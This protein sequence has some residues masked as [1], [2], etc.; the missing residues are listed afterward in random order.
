MFT[1]SRKY[2]NL[3]GGR[4]GH[5][6]EETA[7]KWTHT[8]Y[9]CCTEIQYTKLITN[10]C[11]KWMLIPPTSWTTTVNTRM[12]SM[13]GIKVVSILTNFLFK[14]LTHDSSCKWFIQVEDSFNRAKCWFTRLKT[15]RD[16]MILLSCL[17]RSRSSRAS[18][19][20][21]SSDPVTP[22]FNVLG[23]FVLNWVNLST[24]VSYWIKG[25]LIWQ[26]IFDK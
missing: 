16:Q 4:V 12:G 19:G 9:E 20:V 2:Q 1:S 25:W 23:K 3:C 14:V 18:K 13:P 6:L 17:L 24:L 21:T 8:F 15:R 10:S 26:N 11:Q 5:I 22:R 7:R